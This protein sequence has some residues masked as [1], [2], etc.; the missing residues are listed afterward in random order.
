[1][2]SYFVFKL[3]VNYTDSYGIMM[4]DLCPH[5]VCLRGFEVSEPTTNC[6]ANPSSPDWRG[7]R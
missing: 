5:G 3:M 1:M 2:S 6:T 4:S 7:T